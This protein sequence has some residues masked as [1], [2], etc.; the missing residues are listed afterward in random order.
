LLEKGVVAAADR[1][2]GRFRAFLYADCGLFLTVLA[3]CRQRGRDVLG[4]LNECFQA[5]S[6]GQTAPS[7][8][9]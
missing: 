5:R 8:L 2:K 7:L 4:F 9:A 1:R 3:T 6:E